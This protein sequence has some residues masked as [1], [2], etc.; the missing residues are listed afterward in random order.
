[1]HMRR[2]LC[3]YPSVNFEKKSNQSSHFYRG[4][5]II[6]AQNWSAISSVTKFFAINDI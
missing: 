4:L 1:M 2:M 5:F 3:I 6:F